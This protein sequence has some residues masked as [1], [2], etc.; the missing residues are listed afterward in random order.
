MT[1]ILC[2]HCAERPAAI[3]E[4]RLCRRCYNRLRRLDR[5]DDYPARPQAVIGSDLPRAGWQDKAACRASDVLTFFREATYAD[6]LAVCQDCRVIRQCR[7]FADACE[8]HSFPGTVHGVYGAETPAQRI[9]R[10]AEK[11]GRPSG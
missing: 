9:A 1:D 8:T 4:R 10:R 5:L 11:H 3:R 6:A 2:L 7:A